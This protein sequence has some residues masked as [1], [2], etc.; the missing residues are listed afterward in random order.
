MAQARINDLENQSRRKNFRIRGLPETITDILSTVQEVI[1]SLI[2]AVPEHKLELGR[3]HRS[4]GPPRKDGFPRDIVV[5]PH[6]YT[7]KEEVMK[8]SRMQTQLK[9]Q[10]HNI[11]IF[12]DISP[13]TIQKRRS[14]KL[15]L[16]ALTKKDIKYRWAFPFALKFTH[17]GKQY[18]FSSFPEGERLLLDLR[19]ITQDYS[20]DTSNAQQGS[21]KRPTPTRP[22]S[23]L[24]D[25]S[26]NKK[27]KA[28]FPPEGS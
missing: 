24:W 18:A 9:F 2:P 13:F 7:I 3:A 25:K 12:A 1:K 20:M 23:P 4:L 22:T 6:F 14:L 17:R 27:V 5:K 28:N 15:L 26:K 8:K 21:V 16:L 10:G 11:Q 19:I